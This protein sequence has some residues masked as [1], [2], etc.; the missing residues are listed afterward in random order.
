MTRVVVLPEEKLYLSCCEECSNFRKP[1]IFGCV[2]A[3]CAKEGRLLTRIQH[4]PLI[5]EPKDTGPICYVIPE[6]C[7]IGSPAFK[8]EGALF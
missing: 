1:R 5:G 8:M 7:D 2:P 4:N 6:W 3:F